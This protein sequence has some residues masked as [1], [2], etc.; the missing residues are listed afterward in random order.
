MV[1]LMVTL[2]HDRLDNTSNVRYDGYFK[3][4]FATL[5]DGRLQ[6]SGQPVPKPR[7]LYFKTMGWCATYGSR[8]PRSLP[9]PSSASAR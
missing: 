3:P 6:L 5:P 7:H 4:Y 9:T 8:A 2:A 1:V